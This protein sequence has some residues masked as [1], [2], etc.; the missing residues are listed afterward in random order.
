MFLRNIGQTLSAR[1]RAD[2]KRL[3]D[4]TQFGK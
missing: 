3:A 4:Y 1:I 2:N